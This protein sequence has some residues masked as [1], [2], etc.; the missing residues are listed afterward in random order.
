MRLVS[1]VY[2]L[3]FFLHQF[4][5]LDQP[6]DFGKIKSGNNLVQLEW[7]YSSSVAVSLSSVAP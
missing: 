3:Y 6:V 5:N 7:G 4:M 1:Y 2:Y